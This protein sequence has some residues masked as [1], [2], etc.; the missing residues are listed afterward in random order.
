LAGRLQALLT[1]L[2]SD[3]P[4]P[5]GG[6]ASA[7]A[8]AVAAA[9]LEKAAKLSAAH[10]T[11]AAGVGER[12]HALRLQA[13]ELLEADAH[14]YMA[15]VEAMR[16]ARGMVG[17]TRER[18]IGPAHSKTVDVPLGIV[19]SGAEAVGLAAQLATHGN[20]N[21]RADAVV[22]ATLAA[23]AAQAAAS[24]MAVNLSSKQGDPRLSE[25]R[26]LATA[27]DQRAAELRA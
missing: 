14:A 22:A 11:G 12:A 2:A 15:F 5:A 20:P 7:A 3:Q 10:W 18:A 9:L 16:A 1:G 4:V 13:E 27:A 17:E 8:V 6:S 26:R 25:A 23:A 21:L 24:L 19:R